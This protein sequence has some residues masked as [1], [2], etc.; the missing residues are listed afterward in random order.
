VRGGGAGNSRG[1]V[2]GVDSG[3]V[4]FQPHAVESS[5]ASISETTPRQSGTTY[6]AAIPDHADHEAGQEHA[7][8]AMPKQRGLK[9]ERQLRLAR[10]VLIEQA[11]ALRE[12]AKH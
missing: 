4:C 2:V 9:L 3:V 12:L 7:D 1:R 11:D 10:K 5:G 8:E 6:Q